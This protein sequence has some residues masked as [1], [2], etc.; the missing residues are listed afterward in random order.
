VGDYTVQHNSLT[1]GGNLATFGSHAGGSGSTIIQ[2]REYL[3]DV[4]STTGFNSTR[5]PL[6]VGRKEL[7]PWLSAVACSFEKYRIRGIVVTYVPTSAAIGTSNPAL[8]S[9]SLA[10]QYD[11]YD[12][13][14]ADLRAML[15]Y[16]FSTSG[17][18]AQPLV[19]P[20]ECAKMAQTSNALYTRNLDVDA[21]RLP[22]Y[23]MGVVT[24]ATQG[25]QSAGY[26]LGQLWVTYDVELLLPRICQD[27]FRGVAVLSTIAG[28]AGATTLAPFRNAFVNWNN[29]LEGFTFTDNSMTFPIPGKYRVNISAL[30]AGATLTS[31]W[32]VTPGANLTLSP[33]MPT[34]TFA[35]LYGVVDPTATSGSA[36]LSFTVTVSTDNYALAANTLTVV[37][38]AGYTAAS[39]EA[40][41]EGLP[42]AM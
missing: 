7:F 22:F 42:L 3:A 36:M 20:I 6:N 37:G 28:S 13:Q 5:Y 41:I 10:T 4:Q 38:P 25:Q 19:H 30:Q 34:S 1:I 24:V 14:F 39:V 31:I 16:Q 21:S 40:E 15:S 17:T 12:P 18:P 26:T 8:G 35:G 29:L 11:P 9:V 23:D 33:A 2:H 32:V 27:A